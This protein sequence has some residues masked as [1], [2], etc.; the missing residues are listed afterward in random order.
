MRS[1][2]ADATRL[3]IVGVALAAL[4]FAACVIGPKQ[5]DPV[6]LEDVDA[7]DVRGDTSG[8]GGGGPFDGTDGAVAAPDASGSD[9]AAPP[10]VDSDACASDGDA[11]VGDGASDATG[12]GDSAGDANTDGA[13]DAVSGG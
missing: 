2:V 5:D 11:C 3:T 13:S 9:T 4:T 6:A 12:D 7:G 10:A 1:P 8:G